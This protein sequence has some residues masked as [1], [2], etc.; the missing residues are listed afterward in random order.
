MV[1][2]AGVPAG[3]EIFNLAALVVF[4]SVIVHGVTDTPGANW[5]ARRSERLQPARGHT[6]AV[7]TR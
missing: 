5:L 4:C 1:L 7:E 3:G 6:A 2:S